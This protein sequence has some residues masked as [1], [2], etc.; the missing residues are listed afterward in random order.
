ML[1][2]AELG[3]NGVRQKEHG[4]EFVL[5]HHIAGGWKVI[6]GSESSTVTLICPAIVAGMRVAHNRQK[7]TRYA[8]REEE[9]L[10]F[11]HMPVNGQV[12]DR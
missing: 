7:K 4:V 6:D 2:N 5:A 9:C 11:V 1:L 10:V 12:R 8:G 3:F